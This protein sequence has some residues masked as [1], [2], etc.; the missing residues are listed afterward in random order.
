LALA[1]D[2]VKG[3]APLHPDWKY[4][5]PFMAALAGGHTLA[6]SGEYDLAENR[7]GHARW[8]DHREFGISRSPIGAFRNSDGDLEM[9]QWTTMAGGVL[10]A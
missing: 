4:T 7:H 3:M 10:L 1:L 2:R 6:E 9:L 8:H 5:Q